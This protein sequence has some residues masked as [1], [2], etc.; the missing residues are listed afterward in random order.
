MMEQRKP[1]PGQPMGVLDWRR[2]VASLGR[3]VDDP[4]ALAQAY[5][6]LDAMESALVE[7]AQRLMVE[8]YSYADLARPFGISRQGARKR[9]P[10]RGDPI[11]APAGSADRAHVAAEQVSTVGRWADPG[12][13]ECLSHGPHPHVRDGLFPPMRC[14][15]CQTCIREFPPQ[16]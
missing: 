8:G 4:D 12:P 3:Q 14:L 5:T 15:D 13:A 16:G 11:G 9:W 6:V 7:A 2:T 1:G 10:R